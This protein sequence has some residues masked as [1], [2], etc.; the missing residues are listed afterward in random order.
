MGSNN[1]TIW[2]GIGFVTILIAG[3]IVYTN[4]NN[5]LAS[6]QRQQND[7]KQQLAIKDKEIAD[8]QEDKERL[9]ADKTSNERDLD[10]RLGEIR[11]LQSNIGIVGE[12]LTGVLGVMDSAS[13]E[14][15]A[16]LIISLSRLAEPCEKSEAILEEVKNVQT[17]QLPLPSESQTPSEVGNF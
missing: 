4:L 11:R 17:N 16:G 13:R 7:M 1:T 6:M 5:Q 10:R 14:D 9:E 2:L 12:C 8:L 15:T 3:G